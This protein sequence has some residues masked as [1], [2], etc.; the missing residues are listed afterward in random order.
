MKEIVYLV[1]YSKGAWDSYMETPIFVTD[2]IDKAKAYVKKFN[3][4][5]KKVQEHFQNFDSDDTNHP[6]W[7]RWYLFRD[8]NKA[9]ITEIEKR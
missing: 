1:S 5:L 4:K 6:H 7:D 3:Q 8:V 9:F 2:N